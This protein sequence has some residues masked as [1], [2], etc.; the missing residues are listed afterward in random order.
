MSLEVFNRKSVQVEATDYTDGE[1]VKTGLRWDRILSPA[2]GD[3]EPVIF[4]SREKKYI[5]KNEK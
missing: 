2:L 1:R 4:A 5:L 3:K